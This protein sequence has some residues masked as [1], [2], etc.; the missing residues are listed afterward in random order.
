MGHRLQAAREAASKDASSKRPR[1]E[2]SPTPRP[3]AQRRKSGRG[4]S[5]KTKRKR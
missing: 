4:P 5:R 1:G 2:N 3:P